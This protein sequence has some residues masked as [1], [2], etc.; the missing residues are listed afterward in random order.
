MKTQLLK[1]LSIIYLLVMASPALSA[2]LASDAGKS[3][4]VQGQLQSDPKLI[5]IN[6][7]WNQPT[8]GRFQTKLAVP[9]GSILT[10]KVRAQ[11]NLSDSDEILVRLMDDSN[12]LLKTADGKDAQW[13]FKGVGQIE[14]AIVPESTH[15][16]LR[17]G[18]EE[19]LDPH[20]QKPAFHDWKGIEDSYVHEQENVMFAWHSDAPTQGQAPLP[21]TDTGI[22]SG[23]STPANDS[24]TENKANQ[25]SSKL[26]FSIKVIGPAF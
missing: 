5:G 15:L 6:P 24:V 2:G 18:T 26:Q 9:S 12:N 8:D 20:A 17:V 10:F 3:S 21:G 23:W 25:T 16:I 14:R 1:I 19:W 4:N 11:A 13:T 22:S 7:F